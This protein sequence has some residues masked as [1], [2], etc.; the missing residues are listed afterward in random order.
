VNPLT[1][2]ISLLNG[3]LKLGSGAPG[4][5]VSLLVTACFGLAL[6]LASGVVANRKSLVSNA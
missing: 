6:L 4:I 5:G 2:S 1:Y 3:L